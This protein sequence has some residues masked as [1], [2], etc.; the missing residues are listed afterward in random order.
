MR[1]FRWTFKHSENTKH[2]A[3][4][5]RQALHEN[6]QIATTKHKDKIPKCIKMFPQ[7]ASSTHDDHYS[8]KYGSG[9]RPPSQTGQQPSAA[10]LLVPC[11]MKWDAKWML[12][13]PPE[14]I[15]MHYGSCCCVRL[16]ILTNSILVFK[17]WHILML[18]GSH[19]RYCFRLFLDLRQSPN[20]SQALTLST[21]ATSHRSHRAGT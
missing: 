21:Q 12:E 14:T 7:G 9:L 8:F 6:I 3:L 10:T 4:E 5:Q 17:F 15:S 16:S 19:Q 18:I 20:C 1:N 13:L 2:E 11:L